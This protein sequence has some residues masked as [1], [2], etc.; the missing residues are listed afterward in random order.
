MVLSTYR[1]VKY[2]LLIL[3][4][5][6]FAHCGAGINPG[7]P[8]SVAA[9][10]ATG[11]ATGTTTGTATRTDPSTTQ[12]ILFITAGT[13]TGNLKGSYSSGIAGADAIYMTEAATGNYSGTYKAMI[14][15]GTL[16]V[17]CTT[18][19]CSGGPSEHTDWPLAANTTYVRG[20]GITVIA[21]TDSNGLLI[22][23]LSTSLTNA[24]SNS[25][26]LIWVGLGRN[27]DWTTGD[28]GYTCTAWSVTV[29]ITLG[30]YAQT[31]VTGSTSVY[32]GS[33]TCGN[34]NYLACV[35]Q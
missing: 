34:Y 2:S 11:T 4:A 27:A 18:A 30:R 16:R 20:D 5:G 33:E 24:Y 8:N 31:D 7:N 32:D 29:G 28:I 15:D 17:A 35:Q 12:K 21:T 3:A 26:Y 25:S 22:D 9:G 23:S 10:T 13:Y 6:L 19:Y 14:V 1:V